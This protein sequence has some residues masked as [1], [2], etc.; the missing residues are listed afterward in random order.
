MRGG[1]VL[2]AEALQGGQ[3][4]AAVV[5]AVRGGVRGGHRASDGM[6]APVVTCAYTRSTPFATPSQV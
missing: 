4:A 6:R 3:Q 5:S 2:V 1:R